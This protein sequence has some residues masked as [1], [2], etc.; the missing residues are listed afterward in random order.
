MQRT[1]KS[2]LASSGSDMLFHVVGAPRTLSAIVA[3]RFP[4][5]TLVET[6]EIFPNNTPDQVLVIGTL[7]NGGVFSI[8][9]EGGKRNGSGLQI[10]ITRIGG[11]F[12]IS[13]PL[14]FRTPD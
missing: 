6:G 13:Q 9:I 11:G 14:P 10:D 7:A 5:I 3:P 2:G 12:K 4:A 8:Q 1:A